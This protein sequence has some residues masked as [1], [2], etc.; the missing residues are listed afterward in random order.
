MDIIKFNSYLIFANPPQPC[1]LE[2]A[3]DTDG[4]IA[5]SQKADLYSDNP[6]TNIL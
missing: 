4:P 2:Y 5:N 6:S 1:N 3:T